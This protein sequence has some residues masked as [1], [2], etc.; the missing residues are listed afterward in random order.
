MISLLVAIGALALAVIASAIIDPGPSRGD[1][2]E[3]APTMDAI[4]LPF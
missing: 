4:V 3:D 2:D 1:S